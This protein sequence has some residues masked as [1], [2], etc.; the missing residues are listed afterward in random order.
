MYCI[1]ISGRANAGKDTLA[2]M[3]V[4]QMRTTIDKSLMVKYVAL[5]DPIKKM[6]ETMFP[7]MPKKCFYGPSKYRN[8]IIPG[9]FKNGEPLTVRQVLLDIGTEVGRGYKANVWLDVF[10]HTFEMN[11]TRDIFIISDE[12]FADECKHLRSKGFFQIRLYRPTDAP[13]INHISETGQNLISDDEFDY[14]LHN[15]GTLKQLKAKIA[16]IIPLI[17][18]R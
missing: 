15:D 2:H 18:N 9:A 14:V 5:A 6:A 10:D 3:I 12:R 16:E 7:Y 17:P 13:T 11:K 1:A 4:K 8:E